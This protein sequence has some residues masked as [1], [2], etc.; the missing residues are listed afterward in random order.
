[1]VYD[2]KGKP[3][4]YAFV[5]LADESTTRDVYRNMKGKVIDGH[6][7]FLD[8]ERGRTVKDWKPRRLGND[9]NTPRVRKPSK[10]FL[11][12]MQQREAVQEAANRDRRDRGPPRGGDR[13]GGRGGGGGDRYDRERDSRGPSDRSYG[14]GGDRD[15][16]SR[17]HDSSSSKYPRR[18]ERRDDRRDD[19]RD[20]GSSRGHW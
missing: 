7:I 18:E 14:G 17:S 20:E 4:G 8:V 11:K 13:G 9:S 15:R 2:L 19:R 6:E 10:A 1:M 3:R 16:N 12:M 5:E